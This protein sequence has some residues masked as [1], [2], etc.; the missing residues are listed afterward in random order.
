MAAR[1]RYRRVMAKVSDL[2]PSLQARLAGRDLIVF[3]GECV[4]CSGFFRFITRVDRAERFHFAHAQS[5]LGT[6]LFIALDL[7]TDDF[8]TNLIIVD[9]VIY[10]HLDSFAAAMRALGWPYRALGVVRI[11]PGPLKTFL[12]NRIARNRYALFGRYDI[13]MMPE[14][15][16]MARFIDRGTEAA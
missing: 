13:C 12:Y 14:P 9:G 6:D 16:L 4:L 11:L 7:P 5:A 1:A 8:Q 10:T 3:D 15:A 2:P